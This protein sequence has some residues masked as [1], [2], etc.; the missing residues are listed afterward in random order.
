M[1]VG[2][3]KPLDGRVVVL[4][5]TNGNSRH[6]TTMKTGDDEMTHSLF[7]RVAAAVFYGLASFFI[8]VA[9]KLVLTSYK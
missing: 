9:N 3:S 2:A 4:T 5:E 6:N 7:A 8:I 1:A